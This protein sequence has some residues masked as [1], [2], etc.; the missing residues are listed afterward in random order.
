MLETLLVVGLGF[1]VVVVIFA[2]YGLLTKWQ[3]ERKRR[4]TE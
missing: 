2:K 4:D 3:D 1:L